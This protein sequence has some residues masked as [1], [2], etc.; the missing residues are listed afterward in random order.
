MRFLLLTILLFA[1]AIQAASGQENTTELVNTSLN[2]WRT[3]LEAGALE[4]RP[5]IVA[6]DGGFAVSAYSFIDPSWYFD[7][8]WLLYEPASGRWSSYG[9]P[10]EPSQ[11]ANLDELNFVYPEIAHMLPANAEPGI[12]LVDG[13]SK[14][15]FL[16]D[17]G[18]NLADHN[19]YF[20]VNIIDL[21]TG[22]V[23]KFNL[24]SCR[25]MRHSDAIVWEF[26]EE[27]LI[28]SCDM[29]IWYDGDSLRR[30]WIGSYLGQDYPA[31]LHLL[32]TSPDN[33]FWILRERFWLD[34]WYGDTYL[35]DRQTGW[36][37]VLL[38]H[39]RRRPYNFAAWLSDSI[40]IVNEGDYLMHFDTES[41]ERRYAL[42]DEL[43]ALPDPSAYWWRGPYLSGDGQWLLVFTEGGGLVL[44][45]VFDALA[46][47]G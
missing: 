21:A 33:R 39:D 25:G 37:T 34:P 13:G 5:D 46:I 8:E 20:G 47:H 12:Q 27:N 3:V 30:E 28:V 11:L 32:S 29:L 31:S 19:H 6:V 10:H 45:N 35:Y 36:T 9:D 2:G 7:S 40:L 38:W 14:A 41:Y 15:V 24:W 43:L 17:A 4:K 42:E 23:T 26:P 44:R 18:E 16:V 1:F 22:A